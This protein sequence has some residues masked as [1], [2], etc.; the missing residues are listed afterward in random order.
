[1]VD[2]AMSVCVCVCVCECV[3]VCWGDSAL[4]RPGAPWQ[5]VGWVVC[6]PPERP[7]KRFCTRAHTLTHTHTHTYLHTHTYKRIHTQKHIET[8]PLPRYRCSLGG[9]GR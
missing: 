6:I 7:G 4:T 2:V 1:S 5:E 3:C 8:H 9:G